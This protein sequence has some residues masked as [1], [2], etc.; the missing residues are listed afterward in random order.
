VRGSPAK[1]ILITKRR[2][3][4][5]QWNEISKEKNISGW[6]SIYGQQQ[7]KLDDKSATQPMEPIL[8]NGNTQF[9]WVPPSIYNSPPTEVTLY[10]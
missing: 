3:E 9:N 7:K 5:Q 1:Q 6:E 8:S 4:V 10:P 2:G